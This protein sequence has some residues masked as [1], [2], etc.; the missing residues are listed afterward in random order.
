MS[1]GAQNPQT[2]TIQVREN[3]MSDPSK[4]SLLEFPCEFPIKA[5]GYA[6]PALSRTVLDMVLKHAPDTD[7]GQVS[8][9]SSAGGKY[10]AVTV[11]ITAVDQQQIDAIYQELTASSEIL[12]AL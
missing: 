2:D 4:A 8:T 1:K 11:T 9:R 7:P 6:S 10:S 12:M 5:F 3:C